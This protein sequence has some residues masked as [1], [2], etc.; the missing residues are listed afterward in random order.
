MIVSELEIKMRV[1]TTQV[2]E[3][4]R[5][6][7]LR[8]RRLNLDMQ[9]TKLELRRTQMYAVTV[10]GSIMGMLH[11]VVGMLPEPLRLVASSVVGALQTVFTALFWTAQALTVAGAANPLLLI[12]A[13]FAWVGVGMSVMAVASAVAMQERL[14]S[15][16][17]RMQSSM[18]QMASSL[19]NIIS[20]LGV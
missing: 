7:Q 11:A 3:K 18:A 12:Q 15:D 6:W 4:E 8:L 10:M 5:E 16:M 1:D 9:R 14:D 17:L 19:Q 13:T 2:E 20:S